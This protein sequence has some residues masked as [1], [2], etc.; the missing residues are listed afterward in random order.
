MSP[1]PNRFEALIGLAIIATLVTGFASLLVALFAFFNA[2]WTGSGVCLGAAALA[3][4]LVAHAIL[5]T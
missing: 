5:P 1:K 4:G 2:D 3:F